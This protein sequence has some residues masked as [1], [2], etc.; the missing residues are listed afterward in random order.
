M[1]E[2]SCCSTFS[3][4]LEPIVKAY[5]YMTGIFS[6]TDTSEPQVSNRDDQD[7]KM[8][9]RLLE[10]QYNQMKQ[11]LKLQP[12]IIVYKTGEHESVPLKSMVKG[13]LI[14]REVKI[15]KSFA[16][17]PVGK[18]TLETTSWG[19]VQYNSLWYTHLQTHH[20]SKIS[21]QRISWDLDN[22]KNEPQSFDNN[23]LISKGD[24]TL[25]PKELGGAS[26]QS[27]L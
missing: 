24:D 25:Q 21:G 13:V 22:H 18:V 10:K 26:E 6:V 14:N 19:N 4:L 16:D 27:A 2:I 1:N 8:E 20:L 3:S 5:K 9:R 7:I 15:L 11:K 17:D 23:R 12:P